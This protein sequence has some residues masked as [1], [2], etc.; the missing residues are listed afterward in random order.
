MRASRKPSA[1]PARAAWSALILF[2]FGLIVAVLVGSAG[3]DELWPVAVPGLVTGVGTLGLA[4]AT[5]A[6]LRGDQK[7]RRQRD[8]RERRN[9]AA[10]VHVSAPNQVDIQSH[11]PIRG[12]TRE[13]VGF[14][15]TIRNGSEFPVRNVAAF[16]EL[17]EVVAA[18]VAQG[19]KGDNIREIPSLLPAEERT[20][21]FG[22]AWEEI[23]TFY[24]RPPRLNVSFSDAEGNRW[25]RLDN[26]ELHEISGTTD[27]IPFWRV[28]DTTQIHGPDGWPDEDED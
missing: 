12:R 22:V 26:Y 21:Q 5:F 10:H 2:G 23:A 8:T 11:F 25:V 15:C 3:S 9:Q 13:M 6:V 19:A 17:D 24:K 14:E 16:L 4:A 1:I 28:P 7:D 20:V 27:Y 18:A